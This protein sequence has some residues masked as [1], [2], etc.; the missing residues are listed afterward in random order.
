M[1]KHVN[2]GRKRKPEQGRHG[3]DKWSM[4]SP[5][6]DSFKHLHPLGCYIPDLPVSELPTIEEGAADKKRVTER[7]F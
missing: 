2:E 4:R 3:K 1:R 5:D 7:A 6:L